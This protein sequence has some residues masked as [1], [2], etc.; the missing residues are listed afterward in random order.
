MKSTI[1]TGPVQILNIRVR[2]RLKIIVQI[3]QLFQ[4]I[5][6]FVCE[7]RRTT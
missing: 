5:S 2:I 1:Q 6:V 4:C 3:M 7:I